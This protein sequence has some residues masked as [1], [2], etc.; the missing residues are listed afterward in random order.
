M[1]SALSSGEL[2]CDD[3]CES[4]RPRLLEW[5]KM[6]HSV[7]VFVFFLLLLVRSRSAPWRVES[8]YLLKSVKPVPDARLI[9]S[10][11]ITL[12]TIQLENFNK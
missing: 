5:H 11:D 1:T 3:P 2:A 6:G 8:K 10:D 12:H 4:A 7:V 9:K